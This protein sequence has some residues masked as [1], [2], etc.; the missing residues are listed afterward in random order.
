MFA[1][2]RVIDPL[3]GGYPSIHARLRS[4]VSVATGTAGGD[5]ARACAARIRPNARVAPVAGLEK[6]VHILR[7]QPRGR[8]PKAVFAGFGAPG[9][10][11]EFLVIRMRVRRH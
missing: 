4:P 10:V 7:S 11:G 2:R 6:A 8:S 3:Y 5:F 1:A 9:W